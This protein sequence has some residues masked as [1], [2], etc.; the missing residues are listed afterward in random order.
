ML[1]EVGNRRAGIEDCLWIKM[2]GFRA[3]LSIAS[4]AYS[5]DVLRVQGRK[6]AAVCFRMQVDE[7]FSVKGEGREGQSP[8]EWRIKEDNKRGRKVELGG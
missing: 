3:V 2:I 4:G 6:M 7:G 5:R 1:D 8:L